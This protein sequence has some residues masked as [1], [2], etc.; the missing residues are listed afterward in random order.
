MRVRNQFDKTQAVVTN[1]TPGVAACCPKAVAAGRLPTPA[2]SAPARWY[3]S[4][5]P[6]TE[7]RNATVAVRQATPTNRIVRFGRRVY[8]RLNPTQAEERTIKSSSTAIPA[9]FKKLLSHTPRNRSYGGRRST[10][11]QRHKHH[12]GH[13][14]VYDQPRRRLSRA[15]AYL[16]TARLSLISGLVTTP[17][18]TATRLSV[19]TTLSGAGAAK[20]G[21]AVRRS[22]TPAGLGRL[23]Y[24]AFVAESFYEPQMHRLGWVRGLRH[25]RQRKTHSRATDYVDASLLARLCLDEHCAPEGTTAA[26]RRTGTP[27]VTPIPRATSPRRSLQVVDGIDPTGWSCVPG[28]VAFN[29]S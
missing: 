24:G 29:A 28:T 11:L 19:A 25:A 7:Q 20:F 6:D 16:S 27:G 13:A 8:G 12:V 14:Y 1:P 9:G 18:L 22:P 3:A 26:A 4:R 21:D 5:R 2:S 17:G 23:A 15:F 10:V